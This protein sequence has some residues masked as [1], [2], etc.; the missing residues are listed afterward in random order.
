[1]PASALALTMLSA[2]PA[3]ASG[4]PVFDREWALATFNVQAIRNNFHAYGSGVVVAVIDGGVDSAQPDL[5]GQLVPGVNVSDPVHPTSDT[6]DTTSDYHGTHVT[7]IIVA[8]GHGDPSNLQGL[9]G[10]ASRAKAMPVKDGSDHS[11]PITETAAIRYAADHG[12]RV[13]NISEGGPGACTPDEAAAINYALSKN[14]VIVAAAGNDGNTTNAS[15]CPANQAGVMSISA[16]AQDGTMDPYS[17]FGSDVTVAAPGVD[18]EA[19]APGGQYTQVR[20]SSDA[21]PWVSAEAALIVSLHPDWTVG[22]VIRV[23]INNTVTGSGKRVDDH[24]GYGVID[25]LKALGAAA[26]ADTSNPLGGP[27]PANTNSQ[28]ASGASA[29]PGK[30]A[31][32]NLYIG[33]AGG[34]IILAGAAVFVISRRRKRSADANPNGGAN[35][36]QL[37]AGPSG[38]YAQPQQMQVYPT[39]DPRPAQQPGQSQTPPYN[40][41]R[42]NQPPRQQ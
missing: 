38:Q 34:V 24:V 18:I 10:L 17:H 29:S 39:Q 33:I 37:A 41:P 21:A 22:Q 5:Q 3:Q 32:T 28:S 7:A 12:A 16:I 26:P 42:N 36:Q 11:T 15:S 20:G 30:P 40:P 31:S 23:I 13:I 25:P 2:A 19:P 9:V 8:H 27:E 4:N 35:N 14:I 6:S 1:M